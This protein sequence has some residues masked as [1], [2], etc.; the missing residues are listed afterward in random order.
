MNSP[1][2]VTVLGVGGL[3]IFG[4][5]LIT[6]AQ[7]G[8]A[9]SASGQMTMVHADCSFFGPDCDRFAY[10]GLNGGTPVSRHGRA[11]S[12]MTDLVGRMVAAPPPGSSPATFGRRRE[13]GSIDPY[14]QADWKA[15]GITP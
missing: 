6:K 11:L 1:H 3:L 4:G 7:D 5:A 12:G 9:I 15:N 8:P 10:T 2:W 13:A 14:L